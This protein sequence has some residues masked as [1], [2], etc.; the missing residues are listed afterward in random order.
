MEFKFSDPKDKAVFTC[1]HV[2]HEKSPVLH[3]THDI[4]G[5]WQ[6]LC[7]HEAHSVEDAHVISLQNA[8]E[9]DYS[10]N[11]LFEMPNGVGAERKKMGAKWIPFRL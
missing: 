7:G 10:L 5:D 4:D 3:V 6:F 8:V 9:L 11:D 2:I 1:S